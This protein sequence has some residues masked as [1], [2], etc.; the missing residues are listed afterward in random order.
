MW[1]SMMPMYWSYSSPRSLKIGNENWPMSIE[2][3]TG[4]G[5]FR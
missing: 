2:L 3:H 4:I 1:I 5:V